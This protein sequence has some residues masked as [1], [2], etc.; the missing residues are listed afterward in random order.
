M[1]LV[2]RVDVVGVIMFV[3]VMFC[4][5]CCVVRWCWF[6]VCGVGVCCSVC[7][8]VVL[9][10][11]GCVLCWWWCGLICVCFDLLVVCF[12]VCVDVCRFPW[13]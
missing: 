10:G 7:N 9:W 13:F 3:C 12:V 6:V 1:C 8:V 2:Y 4:L 5:L 11:I